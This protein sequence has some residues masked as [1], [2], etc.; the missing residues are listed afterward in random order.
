VILE[1]TLNGAKPITGEAVNDLPPVRATLDDLFRRAAAARPDALALVDP[2]DRLSFT[3]GPVRRLT[4]AQA[5]RAISALAARL[6]GF[7]LPTDSVVAI[8]LPNTVESVIALLAVLRAGLIAAPLPLLWRHADAAAALSRVAARALIGCQRIGDTVHGDLAMHI[9][10]ETFTIRFLCGFG[11]NLPDGVV[12]IDDIFAGRGEPPPIDRYGEASDHVA[13]VTF[14]ITA[15]GIVPI[16]RS[17][18]ELIAGGLAVHLEARIEPEATV[19]GALAL[20]SFAGLA[21]TVV[22]WLLTAGTLVLHHPFAPAVF[23]AQRA[24]ERCT[25]AVLPGPMVMRLAEAGLI[26]RPD[27]PTV[28]GVWRAPERLVASPAW[29]GGTL[30][31]IPVFGEVGLV[32]ARR[33]ADGK[34]DKIPAGRLVL[35]RGAPQGIHV[36]DLARTAGGTLALSGPMVPHA[37]VPARRRTQRRAET[38][39]CGGQLRYRVCLPHRSRNQDADH[40]WPAWRH[41][42]RRGLSL[43]AARRAGSG[44]R[45]RGRLDA[46]GIAGHARGSAPCRR[47]RRPRRDLRCAAGTWR[48][49]P[50]GRGIPCP[51][52]VTAGIGRLIRSEKLFLPR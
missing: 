1:D 32:A 13:L 36:L 5:D 14:D 24:D 27:D 19:L 52:T 2:P 41:R 38:E 7:G 29:S 8:Q 25:V 49:P 26:G 42:Q 43:L 3:D 30:V 18:A 22:P 37:N 48:Q 23:E 28:L 21:T 20:A 44:R 51:Q 40:R 31:D 45:D 47:G 15:E 35:P 10:M 11:E 17:H 34:P 46:R 4:Y 16:A 6:R 12:P 9:A 33:R 39:D 50:A